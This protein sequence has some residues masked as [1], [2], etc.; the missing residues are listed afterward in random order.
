MVCDSDFAIGE[1]TN[2]TTYH[3]VMPCFQ[4]EAEIQ[5]CRGDGRSPEV[6]S[7]QSR[8]HSSC[9]RIEI[10]QSE[11]SRTEEIPY[12]YSAGSVQRT[13]GKRKLSACGS[14]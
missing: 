13:K 14:P 5:R 3:R 7:V 11:F 4:V 9:R 10:P 8:S 2:T 12:Y 6:P 1:V